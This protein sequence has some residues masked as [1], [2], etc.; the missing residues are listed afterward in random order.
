MS[1]PITATR[2][3]LLKLPKRKWD[4]DSVYDT[5][6][7]IP[8]RTKHDSGYAHINVI[9]TREGKAVEIASQCPDHLWFT[10][11]SE[12]GAYSLSMD[13]IFENKLFQVFSGGYKI[14]VGSGL[15]SLR[16]KLLK[17]S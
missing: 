2:A 5:L 7:L 16:I 3:E 6:I 13:C 10:E 4:E 17:Q 1:K 9:G 8:S 15:S 12:L 14:W 11:L